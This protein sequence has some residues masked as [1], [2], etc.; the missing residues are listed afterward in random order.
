MSQSSEM[1]PSRVILIRHA[2]KT[3]IQG[4]RDLSELGRQRA[5][6]LLSGV[7]KTVD[8]IDHI[9][10]AKSSRKSQR[11][12]LTVEPYATAHGIPIDESWDTNDH[13][14]LAS[15]LLSS[16]KYRDKNVLICWRHD[17]LEALAHAL[18]AS[19]APAWREDLY[20]RIWLLDMTNDD[21]E[22]HDIDSLALANSQ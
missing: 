10:A 2:Q 18:G 4:D 20:D 15:E 5:E 6:I 11:P 1:K 9:I 7:V 19:Q 3:G 14:Q 21:V 17:T 16:G 12:R 13:E 8:R 22:F